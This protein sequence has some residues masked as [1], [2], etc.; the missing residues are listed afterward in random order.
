M[1]KII[2]KLE[3]ISILLDENKLADEGARYM[4]SITPIDK[5]N[6]RRHTYS[7]GNEI[8]AD[9]PYAQRLDDN[10]SKQTKGKG[11]VKPT[12]DHLEELIRKGAI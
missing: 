2:K 10:W 7:N 9:Y 1:N 5:G 4:R 11:I 12:I 6:A 3:E 8:H